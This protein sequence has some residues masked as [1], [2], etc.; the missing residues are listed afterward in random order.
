VL[1]S[2]LLKIQSFCHLF[3][4][5]H[6]VLVALLVPRDEGTVILQIARN[7]TWWHIPEEPKPTFFYISYVGYFWRW[8]AWTE[9]CGKNIVKYQMVF[10]IIG[11]INLIK[12]LY[13]SDVPKEF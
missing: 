10:I 11:A 4:T 7:K 6:V 1:T 12:Y 8:P 5:W 13:I 2:V 9:T 3:L